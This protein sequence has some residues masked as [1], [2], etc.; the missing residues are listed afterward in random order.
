[1]EAGDFDETPAPSGRPSMS[2][3]RTD[4]DDGSVREIDR[5]SGPRHHLLKTS[6]SGSILVD[7]DELVSTPRT[8]QQASKAFKALLPLQVSTVS[9]ENKVASPMT[10]SSPVR[11]AFGNLLSDRATN[12]PLRQPDPPTVAQDRHQEVDVPDERGFRQFDVQRSPSAETALLRSSATGTPVADEPTIDLG[13]YHHGPSRVSKARP[14]HHHY[15]AHHIVPSG[16]QRVVNYGPPRSKVAPFDVEPQVSSAGDH[17]EIQFAS[18]SSTAVS[19][20]Y[21]PRPKDSP[22]RIMVDSVLSQAPSFRGRPKVQPIA[23][24]SE[25]E[26]IGSDSDASNAFQ[27]AAPRHVFNLSASKVRPFLSSL[28]G[29]DAASPYGRHSKARPMA[30]SYSPARRSPSESTD[31]S[32][33]PDEPEHHQ[34]LHVPVAKVRPFADDTFDAANHPKIHHHF[35]KVQPFSDSPSAFPSQSALDQCETCNATG[36]PRDEPRGDSEMASAARQAG[37]R[38][39]GEDSRLLP[40]TAP[41]KHSISADVKYPRGGGKNV[42]LLLDTAPSKHSI[43]TDVKYPTWTRP[44]THS[45]SLCGQDGKP[46]RGETSETSRRP[47]FRKTPVPFLKSHKR[48]SVDRASSP[49]EVGSPLFVAKSSEDEEAP[50]DQHSRGFVPTVVFGGRPS[51]D[52][53]GGRRASSPAGAVIH[54]PVPISK[55]RPHFQEHVFEMDARHHPVSKVRVAD[56]GAAPAAA[57]REG[58]ES[59]EGDLEAGIKPNARSGR[60]QSWGSVIDYRSTIQWLK[61]VLMHRDSNSTRFTERPSKTEEGCASSPE[62][63]R[64]SENLFASIKAARRLSEKTVVRSGDNNVRFDGHGFKRT[65]SDIERL[66]NEALSIASQVVDRPGEDEPRKEPQAGRP[67]CRHAATDSGLHKRPRLHD[68]IQSYSG[69]GVD[70]KMRDAY[71]REA[72]EA[73]LSPKIPNRGSSKNP[74]ACV[75]PRAHTDRMPGRRARP[76]DKVAMQSLT[77]HRHGQGR[78][79]DK[80]IS[81]GAACDAHG[82]PEN[83]EEAAAPPKEENTGRPRHGISLRRRSHVSLRGAAGFNLAKSRKRQPTARDWSPVRKRFVAAVACISTALVGVILGIYAGL[84]PSIQYYIID[85]SHATVHGNTGCFLGLAVP[86]LFFWPLPLLH[87]RKP[88]ILLSLVVAMPLLFPQALAVNSQRLTKTQSWR[89]MLLASRT[90]MGVALGFASMNFHSTLL[91]LFGASLMSVNPHQEVVDEY[92]ARRHG[93]GMGAWIGIWTWCWIGSLGVGF[94]VGACIIDNYP[95]AWGFY[96]SIIILAVVLFLNVVCPEVRRSA[97]RRSIVEVRTGGEVSRRIARGE[98]MMHRVKTGPKWWGQEVYHGMALSAEM[99]RQPGFAVLTLY[100]AWIYAQVVLIMVLLGSLTSRLYQLRSPA[101]GLLVA[102]AAAGAGLAIPFQKANVFSRS[103]LEQM[104]TNLATLNRRVAWSSHLVRR[105]VFT[106]LLPLAGICYAAVSSG[107]PMHVSVPTLFA[108]SVGFLSCLAIA[109]CNGLVMETFDCSDL[110][111]GMVGR[112]RDATGRTQKRTNYSSFP[113]VTAGFAAIHGLAFVLAAGATAL[114]GLVTRT[115]GQQLSTGLAAGILLLLTLLLLLVLIRFSEVQ[116]IPQCKAE[117]MDRL[118]E[119]RR[120][121]S[122]RRASMPND[123]R[124]IMEEEQAWQPCMIGNPTGKKRRMNVLELGG[125]TRWQEIRKK[126]RLIDAN[127][128][129]NRQAWDQG[130]EALDDQLSDLQRDARDFFQGSA[131]RSRRARR[132]DDGSGTA[133]ESFEM[134]AAGGLHGRYPEREC[135]MS[136]TVGEESDGDEEETLGRRR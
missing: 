70:L 80:K 104:N 48:E 108:A 117:A 67:K 13:S 61:D 81:K 59:T 77:G 29:S 34:K 91:D 41:S 7:G 125:L 83:E 119:V 109:E 33:T 53:A 95:P 105:T 64:H 72:G 17:E 99:M 21:D 114:G 103:R 127:A 98:I 18:G 107:P 82:G 102:S 134:E 24:D 20:A 22:L 71:P 100:S 136:Q 74:R 58:S 113:R 9:P 96:I 4:G 76:T 87:G 128:H 45:I 51:K 78:V 26:H 66:L 25:K 111:S 3:L 8:R 110:S 43:S 73:F 52:E 92:D 16:E 27:W 62:T 54:A 37:E 133:D 69:E 11:T 112:Q 115:L 85:Q 49:A 65:V 126:N 88:Y 123:A 124:A 131:R 28:T 46:L 106:L 44:Q 55:V 36:Q 89:A 129:L 93:G 47:S 15:P 12:R 38:D 40:D 2:E 101:V 122:T 32:D 79:V 35:S 23:E 1:M 94:L 19:D 10:P 90:L 50:A 14:A 60:S 5:G 84:V 120:R 86:T 42:G 97:F 63:R 121:S 30:G 132:T 116:I 68:I 6:T 135:V 57:Q 39:G 31:S 56:T 118:V 130:L 75:D